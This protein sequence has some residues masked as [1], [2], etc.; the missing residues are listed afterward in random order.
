MDLTV[1]YE[2]LLEAVNEAIDHLEDG[3]RDRA[4]G[5]LI[6]ALKELGEEDGD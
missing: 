6:S 5:V 4:H 1:K 3:E 2:A